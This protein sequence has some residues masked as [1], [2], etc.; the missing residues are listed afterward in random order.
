MAIVFGN[1]LS[2]IVFSLDLD[3]WSTSSRELQGIRREKPDERHKSIILINA[4][5]HPSKCST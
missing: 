4:Y 3:E 1:D 2:K 5:M